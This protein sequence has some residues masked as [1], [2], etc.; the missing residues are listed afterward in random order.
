[1][2][3]SCWSSHGCVVFFSTSLF[4]MCHS[5]W[6]I[7]SA[8]RILIYSGAVIPL[9]VHVFSWDRM[10]LFW[11]HEFPFSSA[12]NLKRSSYCPWSEQS[13]PKLQSLTWSLRAHAV[14]SHSFKNSD[15]SNECNDWDGWMLWTGAMKSATISWTLV[16]SADVSSW[17]SPSH[18]KIKRPSEHFGEVWT[19]FCLRFGCKML[20]I[21]CGGV[22]MCWFFQKSL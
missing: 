3:L 18:T 12:R 6:S 7:N 16:T 11:V 22:F 1:M 4:L 2:S 14:A 17:F 10:N 13:S 21:T 19:G 15:L 9:C 5:N 8:V 20:T